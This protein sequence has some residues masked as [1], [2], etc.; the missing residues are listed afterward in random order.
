MADLKQINEYEE[1]L[2]EQMNQEFENFPK[3][4]F[5]DAG[6]VSNENDH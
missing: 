1:T 6:V 2:K 5:R 3:E 4:E